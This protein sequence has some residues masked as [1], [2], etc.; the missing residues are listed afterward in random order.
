MM[1]LEVERKIRT[2]GLG[3]FSHKDIDKMSKHLLWDLLQ[4]SDTKFAECPE[5]V[6][7]KVSVIAT[8]FLTNNQQSV[9]DYWNKDF[10]K[11]KVEQLCFFEEVK[12]NQN[13][14]IRNLDDFDNWLNTTPRKTV[15]RQTS[16]TFGD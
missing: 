3:T 11:P 15:A 8:M 14:K 10:P 12:I 1:D 7:N 2:T 9:D 13:D 5:S 16:D 6:R 4:M